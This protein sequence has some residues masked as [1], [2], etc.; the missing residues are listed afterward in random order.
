MKEETPM[1]EETAPTPINQPESDDNR[2]RLCYEIIKDKYNFTHLTGRDLDEKTSK[3]VV[4]AG[5]VISLYSGFGGIIIKDINKNEVVYINKY[6]TL[7]AILAIGII[8]L[9][10]SVCYA[11]DAYKLRE[12]KTVP[13]SKHF[14]DNYAQGKKN[15]NDVLDNMTSATSEADGHNQKLL[16]D[17]AKR[18]ERSIRLLFAGLFAC[19][20]FVFLSLLM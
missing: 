14:Y 4:F 19:V 10:S 5:V 11:L 13:I 2:W 7:L 1:T 6:Y 3:L 8:L 12:W 15:E 20:I 18:I 9:I 17:K 16:E